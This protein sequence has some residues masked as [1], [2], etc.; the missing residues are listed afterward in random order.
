VDNVVVNPQKE[1][2]LPVTPAVIQWARERAGFSLDEAA[3]AFKKIASWE[4]GESGP[5]YPQLE[6]MADKFKTP[7]AVFFFPEPPSLPSV[8]QSFRTLSPGAF[9]NIPRS[10]RML[11]RKGQAMQLNLAEL[12]D[13]KNQTSQSLQQFFSLKPSTKIDVIAS[14]VREF[15]GVTLDEQISWKSAEVA[16]EQ[17]REA[18]ARVGVYVFKEAFHA[19]SYFGFCLYDEEF[20]IIFVNNTSTKTR[21]IFTLFHE[22]GHLIFH[23]SGIDLRN[24]DFMGNLGSTEKRIEIICNELAAKVLVPDDKLN[25]LLKLYDPNR[26]TAEMLANRF[27]VSRETIYRKMLDRGLI[28]E[29]EYGAAVALWNSQQAKSGGGGSFYNNQWVYLGRRYI[30]LA[31]SRYYQQRFDDVRLAEYLNVKPKHLP[32]FE[33]KLGR[34]T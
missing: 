10:V 29:A 21:Q 23:T 20:P 2:F 9:D 6:Q 30:D 34:P 31:F 12:H 5:S 27:N 16:L 4:A 26:E 15:L 14:K 24:D 19:D 17:W 1:D 11:L 25:E 7:L 22:L 28:V 8:E 13:G 32:T 18:F 3:E 33:M